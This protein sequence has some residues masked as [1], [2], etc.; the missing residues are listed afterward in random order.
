MIT[1]AILG[2]AANGE[3]VLDIEADKVAR[4][5]TDDLFKTASERLSNR[6]ESAK[7]GRYFKFKAKVALM[8]VK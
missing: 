1:Y 3:N 8:K 4:D 6:K 7:K 5:V 2:Q